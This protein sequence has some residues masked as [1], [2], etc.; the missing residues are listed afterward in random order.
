MDEPR[1]RDELLRYVDDWSAGV[2]N[3]AHVREDTNAHRE[4]HGCDAYPTS[5]RRARLQSAIARLIGARGILE[6]GCALGYSALW[7]ADALPADGVVESI[8]RDMIHADLAEENFRREGVSSKAHVVRGE[9][10]EILPSLSR[11]Y[12]LI[13]VDSDWEE[14]PD[15]FPHFLRLLWPGGDPGQF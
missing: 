11:A 12:D 3:Y 4:D 5:S 7:Y 1:D 9:A 6:V 2:D 14:F 10:G 8:E 13:S 15:L